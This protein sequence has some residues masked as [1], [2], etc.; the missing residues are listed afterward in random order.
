MNILKWAL[1]IFLILY[2]LLTL[3]AILQ[4]TKFENL[5]YFHILFI[6]GAILLVLVPFLAINKLALLVIALLLI[7][8]SA[9]LVG[10]SS[11]FHLNH[12]IVRGGIS[13]ILI[14]A[15]MQIYK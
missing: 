15:A 1:N 7:H 14:L 10:L 9:I 3:V 11:E 12:H 4:E 5:K 6:L 8:I 13:I 2:G